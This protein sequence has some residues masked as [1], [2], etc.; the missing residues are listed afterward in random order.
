VKLGSR[1][2]PFAREDAMAVIILAIGGL[3][4]LIGVYAVAIG[5]PV[6]EIERGWSMVISGS[7]LIS[8]GLVVAAL[9]FVVRAVNGLRGSLAAQPAMSAVTAPAALALP[10]RPEPAIAPDTPAAEPVLAVHPPAPVPAASESIPAFAV[11]APTAAAAAVIGAG[12][13][14]LATHHEPE[15]A[16]P[17]HEPEAPATPEPAP[18]AHAFDVPAFDPPE[19]PA[20]AAAE[21]KAADA[22][23]PDWLDREFAAFDLETSHEPPPPHAPE[24]AAAPSLP[25]PHEHE[26]APHAAAPT[27][28]PLI[29]AP[30]AAHEPAP[31]PVAEA[32]S[33]APETPEGNL[34]V[35]GRYDSDGTS[36]VMYSDG[37]IEAQSESGVFRFGSMAE[38]KAFIE[39]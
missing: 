11:A 1:R 34:S 26:P 20:P 36:Y 24:P 27:P 12:A 18:P 13:G 30:A 8:G 35:I 7:V 17:A 4:T 23:G 22:L 29:E 33:T 31:E 6:I 21:P 19:P 3:L 32:P 37:S 9:G 15:P 16:E 28:E 14:Y 10:V 25:E 5:L 2:I 38:L 39:G